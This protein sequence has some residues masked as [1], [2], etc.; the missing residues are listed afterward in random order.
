M[1]TSKQENKMC[2]AVI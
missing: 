1:V 2:G